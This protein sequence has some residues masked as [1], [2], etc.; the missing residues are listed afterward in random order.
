MTGHGRGEG[1]AGIVDQKFT[2]LVSNSLS[3]SVK[4]SFFVIIVP[5]YP[6]GV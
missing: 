3:L 6:F 1:K 2:N 4:S 5:G